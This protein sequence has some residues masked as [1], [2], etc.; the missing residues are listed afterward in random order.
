MKTYKYDEW[1]FYPNCGVGDFGFSS[2]SERLYV[3]TAG[4]LITGILED[5]FYFEKNDPRNHV[6][7]KDGKRI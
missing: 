6:Y 4:N 1:D 7:V 3:D 5:F 2:S